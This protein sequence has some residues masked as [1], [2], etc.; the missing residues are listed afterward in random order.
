MADRAEC[1]LDK[2]TAMNPSESAI[3]QQFLTQATLSAWAVYGLNRF[4]WYQAQLANVKRLM[5]IV[6][7]VGL[8]LGVHFTYDHQAGT[9]LITGLAL[10]SILHHA[11]DAAQSF[12]LQEF[13]HQSTKEKV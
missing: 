6:V 12:T 8:S 11:W 3:L 5:A 1:G 9:L 2:G 7:S 10:Q 13:F 4:P